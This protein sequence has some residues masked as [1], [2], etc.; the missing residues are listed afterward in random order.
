LQHRPVVVMSIRRRGRVADASAAVWGG[1]SP[2]RA[3]GDRRSAGSPRDDSKTGQG[4]VVSGEPG[5]D[6][7]CR[8]SRCRRARH[9]RPAGTGSAGATWMRW[10]RRPGRSPDEQPRAV[11][12]G[13][14]GRP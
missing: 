9:D 7:S 8:T 5:P 1:G 10:S 11:R 12:A 14:S 3:T 4:Q 2:A 6:W 13:S